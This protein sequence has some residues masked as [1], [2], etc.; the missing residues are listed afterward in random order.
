MSD[1]DS[2]NDEMG[3]SE[4][5]QIASNT[6]AKEYFLSKESN[7][8]DEWG[9]KSSDLFKFTAEVFMKEYEIKSS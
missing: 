5:E 1:I 7:L 4:A 2:A 8:L 6:T 9:Q 3:L